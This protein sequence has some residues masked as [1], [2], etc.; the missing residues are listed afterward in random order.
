MRRQRNRRDQQ[1]RVS[2]KDRLNNC[3]ELLR[4]IRSMLN[5]I[6]I[7]TTLG[8]IEIDDDDSKKKSVI[9]HEQFDRFADHQNN[10]T[11]RRTVYTQQI[12]RK[13]NKLSDIIDEI[14]VDFVVN[15][16]DR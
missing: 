11:F 8:F 15:H 12:I 1:N 14:R 2:K 13:L 10:Q 3:S 6:I 7:S 16:G 9:I 4:G 5:N